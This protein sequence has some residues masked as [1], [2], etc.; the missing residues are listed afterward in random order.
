MIERLVTISNFRSI[1]NEQKESFELNYL[2]DNEGSYGGLV[3]LI[4][5][6]NSG[7]S[8][9]LD[10]L[11]AFQ[12]K[13][14][15]AN[16]IPF[17][18]YDPKI[19]PTIDFILHDK[20]SRTKFIA[21]LVDNKIFYSKTIG[22]KTIS[23]E[24]N[25]KLKAQT[26]KFLEYL[27]SPVL[28]AAT[29]N[30]SSAISYVN[31]IKVIVDKILKNVFIT[32]TEKNNLNAY[33]KNAHIVTYLNLEYEN[34]KLEGFISDIED[35]FVQLSQISIDKK[36]TDEALEQFGVKLL[37]N[38]ISYV[39]SNHITTNNTVST[40][41]N[42]VIQTPL[43][44]IKLF[45]LLEDEQY[46]ELQNAYK[47]FH[48]FGK[49]RKN[50]LTNYE[51]KIN[52]SVTKLSN[53]FNEIYSFETEDK[54]HFRLAIESDN[55]YFMISENEEDILLDSQSTGFRWF[56][57][58]FF[59]I[60][61][62]N[63]IEK[64]DIVLLDEPATNLHVAGQI[65]LR[66]QIKKFGMQNGVTFIMSTHSPFLIDPDYL[67]EL[68]VVS[69]I[70]QNSIVCN[71]FT[72]NQENDVDVI[73]PIKTALTVNRHIILNPD[74]LLIFVEGI[75]DYNYLVG[76]KE[77]L[78]YDHINFMPIQGIKRANLHKE[79]LKITKTP[80]LLVDSDG[81]GKYVYDK[82]KD[83]FGIEVFK[84][85]DIE[86]TFKEIED[87]FTKSDQARFHVMDKDYKVT[88]GFKNALVNK[89]IRVSKETKENFIKL[90]KHISA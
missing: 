14:F 35:N 32:E 78:G 57:D 81:A 13:K 74:D 59:N 86:E 56:F 83:K 44:F 50:I 77:L 3:T 20:L 53:L 63:K 65:E 15:V 60:F 73:M 80:V 51:K 47:K 5:E 37:P 90:F 52:K 25:K 4:G 31:A 42:G 34:V 30:S 27:V 55:L 33:I 76:F 54:Y 6:N 66:K 87:L 41:V 88:S 45:E 58:F 72:V 23:C 69:K 7:K 38:I 1:G 75:T 21:E 10:A 8:N 85:A 29:Q 71:K 48:E 19:K 62:D 11:K 2:M 79:L 36:T 84:L 9:F 16:D 17:N 12:S 64:G 43:F 70:N 46:T 18:I 49:K 39:D 40:V 28:K 61:S 26:I 22:T 82:N 24:P 89:K 68:R 67:D